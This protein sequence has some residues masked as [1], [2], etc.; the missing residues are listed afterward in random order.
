MRLDE[1][2]RLDPDSRFVQR[3]MRELFGEPADPK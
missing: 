3:Q 1:A 2:L